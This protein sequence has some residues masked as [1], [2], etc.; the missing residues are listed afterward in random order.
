MM[1]AL[2]VIIVFV[3]FGLE[4]QMIFVPL[5]GRKKKMNIVLMGKKDY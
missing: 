4:T 1:L 2:N 3:S 5:Q